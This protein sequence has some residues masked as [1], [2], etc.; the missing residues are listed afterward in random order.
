MFL[1]EEERDFFRAQVIKLNQE[2]SQYVD[3]NRR[4]KKRVAD[5]E[6]ETAN[7]KAISVSIAFVTVRLREEDHETAARTHSGCQLQTPKLSAA[8]PAAEN[9]HPR[10]LPVRRRLEPRG[11]DHRE[12]GELPPKSTSC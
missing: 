7:Y 8:P 4:L 6:I 9:H 1:L 5:I 2:I 12:P 10:T 11:R 3:E